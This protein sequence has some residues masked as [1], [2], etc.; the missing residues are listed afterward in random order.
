MTKGLEA[1]ITGAVALGL[2]HSLSAQMQT[3]PHM[4][5][6]GG[7]IY[8]PE[9]S[10]ARPEDVGKRARTFVRIFVPDVLLP[11]ANTPGG[12]FET[13]ASLACVYQL[14]AGPRT[15]N[16]STAT[17]VSHGGSKAIAI[18]DAYDYPSAAS[19][20]AAFSTEFGLPAANLRSS[21]RRR[22]ARRRPLRRLRRIPAAGGNSRS[23]W[24]LKWRTLW[25][26]TPRFSWWRRIPTEAGIC[27]PR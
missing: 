10:I 5:T 8:V 26:R 14:A 15:C 16:P 7:T 17:A 3:L 1:I 25:R 27:C 6:A 4:H 21:T 9:S 13:P 2:G 18:V 11:A 20:L 24:I 22:E 12:F 23:P 19:D